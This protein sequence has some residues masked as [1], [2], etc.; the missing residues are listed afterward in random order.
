MGVKYF[1][2]P[3]A[4]PDRLRH[5]KHTVVLDVDETLVHRDN[6]GKINIRPH[7]QELISVLL[8]LGDVEVFIWSAG[9]K[10][11]V[12]ACLSLFTIDADIFAVVRG[13]DREWDIKDMSLIARPKRHFGSVMIVDD[14]NDTITAKIHFHVDEWRNDD[15]NDDELDDVLQNIISYFMVRSTQNRH[16]SE[17]GVF[18]NRDSV[19]QNGIYG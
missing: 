11:H 2:D 10:V 4:V 16:T 15:P 1:T 14:R 12:S 6:S 5:H 9:K 18:G 19:A 13:D 3:T 7:A 17:L 8:S